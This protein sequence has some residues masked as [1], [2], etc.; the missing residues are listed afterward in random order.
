MGTKTFVTDVIKQTLKFYI[1]RMTPAYTRSRI[2]SFRKK[3]A[4]DLHQETPAA[5]WNTSSPYNVT[6][7]ILAKYKMLRYLDVQL[8]RAHKWA[9]F[10]IDMLAWSAR[11]IMEVTLW[12]EFLAE[13]P[14]NVQPFIR[15]EC[16]DQHELAELSLICLDELQSSSNTNKALRILRAIRPYKRIQFQG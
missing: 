5:T 9:S 6:Q 2:S 16:R 15:N 3:I 8:R 13:D 12:L 7:V 10:D 14:K 11:K 4:K 1:G